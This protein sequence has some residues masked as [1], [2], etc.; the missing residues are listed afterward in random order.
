MNGQALEADQTSA[1]ERER[2][3]DSLN[4]ARGIVICALIAAVFWLAAFLVM[5]AAGIWRH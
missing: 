1:H 3:E 4:A 2:E 5:M